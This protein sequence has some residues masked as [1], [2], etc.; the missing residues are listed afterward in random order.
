MRP[1]RRGAS[2]FVEFRVEDTGIGIPAQDLPH[3]CEVFWQ[4]GNR[5]TNKPEVSASDSLLQSVSPRTTGNARDLLEEGSTV[6]AMFLPTPWLGR[7]DRRSTPVGRRR[8]SSANARPSR[9]RST[10]DG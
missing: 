7:R 9:D 4:G 1:V 10:S 3:A 5:L 6:V 8:K 2:A